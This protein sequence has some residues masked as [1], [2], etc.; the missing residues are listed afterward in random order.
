MEDEGEDAL[1]D[2]STNPSLDHRE[3]RPASRR[4]SPGPQRDPSDKRAR[5]K[6]EVIPEEEEQQ[7]G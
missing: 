5:Q 6:G 2:S 1:F 4:P 7:L 3:E